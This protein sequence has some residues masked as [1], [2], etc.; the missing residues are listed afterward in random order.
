MRYMLLITSLI[1]YI[2]TAHAL[3]VLIDPGHG[4]SDHGARTDHLR[5]AD[6]TLKIAKHL[7]RYMDKDNELSYSVTRKI[8]KSLELGDRSDLAHKSGADLFVSIH[9]NASLNPRARGPEIYIQNILPSDQYSFFLANR[10]NNGEASE[11]GTRPSKLSKEEY[12]ADVVGIV[13]DLYR[14]HY[15]EKSYELAKVFEKRWKEDLGY[16]RVRMRQAPFFVVSAVNMPSVLLEVGYLTNSY[17]AKK[18]KTA[19]YQR[20]VAKS[21][22]QAIKDYKSSLEN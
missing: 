21:I 16:R 6:I 19:W 15:I 7:M 4:G 22:Y 2:N 10:E 18:L 20:K 11:R 5:E 13:D 3:Q 12:S 1:L 8:D 9:A 17:E 14:N